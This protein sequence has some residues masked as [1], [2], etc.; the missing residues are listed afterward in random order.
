MKLSSWGRSTGRST[1]VTL[2]SAASALCDLSQVTPLIQASICLS[3]TWR[4]SIS[5]VPLYSSQW[6]RLC[7]CENALLIKCTWL[8]ALLPC[9]VSASSRLDASLLSWFPFWRKC[10]PV[11][12]EWLLS[13]HLTMPSPLGLPSRSSQPLLGL[14]HHHPSSS[15]ASAVGH[16]FPVVS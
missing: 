8:L 13:S 14:C 10:S 12:R 2:S 7:V 1:W 6:D 15:S 11:A 5:E 4:S 3:E 16:L 9:T